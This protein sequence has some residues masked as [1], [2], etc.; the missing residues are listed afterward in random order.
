[1]VLEGTVHYL[2]SH[3][4]ETA[5]ERRKLKALGIGPFFRSEW[6]LWYLIISRLGE[7]SGAAAG[8]FLPILV[9]RSVTQSQVELSGEAA[10]LGGGCSVPF[11]YLE[12]FVCFEGERSGGRSLGTLRVSGKES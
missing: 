12:T 9:G 4:R 10:K 7:G 2:L 11:R 6:N 1:M 5:F 8:K 3:L